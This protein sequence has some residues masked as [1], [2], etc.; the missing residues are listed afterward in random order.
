MPEAARKSRSRAA[1]GI[2]IAWL[3]LVASLMLTVW[4]WRA[5]EEDVRDD[6]RAQFDARADELV[7]RIEQRLI[8]YQHVLRGGVALFNALGEVERQHWFE[9]VSQLE[10]DKFYPG[11]QAMGFTIYLRPE[12]VPLLE[13]RVREEGFEDFRV[14]PAD[15][16]RQAY[17]S[18]LYLEPFDWRN[19]RAFGYDMMSEPV[20]RRAMEEARD[21]GRAAMT[22][23]VRLVQETEHDA[24]AG[25]LVYLPVYTGGAPP[26]TVEERRQL[27]RGFVYSPFRMDDF[28]R[29]IRRLKTTDLRLRIYDGDTPSPEAL[30]YDT[31]LPGGSPY[32]QTTRQ[33]NFNGRVWTLLI[34]A[35]P[36]FEDA[37]DSARAESVLGG[38][39]LLS[40][41]LFGLLRSMAQTEQRASALAET[42]TAALRRSEAKYGSL[43]QA[44][45]DAIIVCDSQ[46][47]IV[48]WNRSATE[49]FGYSEEEIRNQSWLMLVPERLRQGY[50]RRWA[51]AVASPDDKPIGQVLELIALRRSGEEFPVELTLARWSAGDEVFLSAIVRD[52]SARKQ[53]E[54]VLR[55]SEQRFRVAIK[56]ADMTVFHQ[57]REL[58]YQ[59]IYNP[60]LGLRPVDILGKTDRELFPDTPLPTLKQRVLDTGESLHEEIR[61]LSNGEERYFDLVLEPL[62]EDGKVVGI[63]GAAV[64]ITSRKRIEQ[65]LRAS[66]ARFRAT[67]SSAAIG[68]VLTDL[69]GRLLEINPAFEQM[70]GYDLEELKSS[71]WVE[72][73]KVD[74]RDLA[75]ALASNGQL[76]AKRTQA[77]RRKDGDSL[78]ASVTA[79]LVRDDSGQPLLVI[80]LIEDITELKAAEAALRDA[81][82]RLEARVAERTR[83]LEVQTRELARSNAELEQF[84]YVASHDLQ[85]PLRSVAGF[86]QLLERR[87]RDVL[88][89]EGRT[90]LSYIVDGT[91]RMRQ[92]IVDLLA[93][94]RVGA[95]TRPF[96]PVA[97]EELVEEVLHDLSAVIAERH[98]QIDRQPLPV[99]W[100]DRNELFQLFLNLIGNAL[101]FNRG[102][103]VRVWIWAEERDDEWLFAV[104]DNGIGIAPQ[105]SERIFA[106]FQQL[107]RRNE[108]PGTG[109]G[110]AICKKVVD[111]HHG[112]IWV[113]SQ[114]GQGSTFYFTL[115]KVPAAA[116]I[117]ARPQA[118]VEH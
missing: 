33:I 71:G 61:F 104:R 113:E 99:V 110:L 41:V 13:R 14:W 49:L 27:L 59:W 107:N 3:V 18:I 6:A 69:Q 29:G 68:I 21:E 51:L 23:K 42:M 53:S 19:Q 91:G 26:A 43:V 58:R 92:L 22:G 84:A 57:D 64:D 55:L 17:T 89:E 111:R 75:A 38:G 108:Y 106:I 78:W 40:L 4:A 94:S 103:S 36:G 70:L 102:E 72:R 39:V 97:T 73:L 50:R 80:Y 31:G 12:Q 114:L 7:W 98:A 86:A 105:D 24:Q 65:E 10:L 11:M 25:F 35:E 34:A 79:S 83:E 93:F 81:N 66:E 116:T 52:V 45:A 115:K 88:D 100:G 77:Y 112:R 95:Q 2:R 1:R 87:Y 46:G 37:F 30:L 16:P 117:A 54:A 20:R 15:P 109:V 74:D 90:Y 82:R 32:Y 67:F 44:A 62:L 8:A 118:N 9:Y 96:Q 85:E 101:K 76:I 56:S 5:T 48:S 60:P 63:S 28:M 47:R